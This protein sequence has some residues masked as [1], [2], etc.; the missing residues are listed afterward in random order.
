VL[1]AGLRCV[2][3]PGFLEVPGLATW[4][5]G[6]D[7]VL[8]F[9]DLHAG[10]HELVEAGIGPHSA[11]AVPIDGLRATAEA[12]RERDALVHLHVAET[13]HEAR[14]LEKEFGK[15]VP[16]ILADIG[17][18]ECRVLA[19]HSVWL[20]DDDLQ[21]YAD[22]GVTVAHCP[23]SNAKLACG[24]AR[25]AD[26]LDAGIRVGLGTDSPA[27]NNDLDLWDEM[28]VAALLARLKQDDASVIS[29]TDALTMATR[30]GAEAL[31]RTDIGVIEPGRWADLILVSTDSAAFIPQIADRDLLSHLV[32][33]AGSRLVT[34]V[35]VAGRK[36][37]EVGR[38]L[39]V[40]ERRARHEVQERARRLA[41]G[42]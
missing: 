7:R 18:L 3:T 9:H 42:S 23:T 13:R 11:Y 1:D 6:L 31:G 8:A 20:S 27:S 30:G 32:W 39:T 35:W 19:A 14:S 24:I 29:A 37:V 26:M 25:V 22:H 16:A 33:S 4:R 5:E 36:V 38:C 28:R 34:D 41:A 40:D 10:R 21:I 2:L 17:L 15:S 12:A